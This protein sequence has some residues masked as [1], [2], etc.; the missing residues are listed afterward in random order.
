MS[1]EKNSCEEAGQFGLLYVKV[2]GCSILSQ[3]VTRDVS[4]WRQQTGEARS[5]NGEAGRAATVR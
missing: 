4:G 2:N 5:A 1:R 3:G